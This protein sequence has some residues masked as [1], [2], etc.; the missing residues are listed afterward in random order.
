M[1]G[2]AWL[3]SGGLSLAYVIIATFPL[4]R[5]N[6]SSATEVAD[7]YYVFI[8]LGLVTGAVRMVNGSAL[9]RRYRVAHPPFSWIVIGPPTSLPHYL[10]FPCGLSYLAFGPRCQRP[11]RTRLRSMWQGRRDKRGAERR[12]KRACRACSSSRRRWNCSGEELVAPRPVSARCRGSA[13]KASVCPVWWTPQ[14][15]CSTDVR[16]RADRPRSQ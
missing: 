3:V 14:S 1:L 4:A 10:S 15:D 16:V 12:S 2:V 11:E 9:L 5:G 6:A 8:L 7:G 13:S